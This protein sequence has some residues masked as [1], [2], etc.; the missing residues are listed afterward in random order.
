MQQHFFPLHPSTLHVPPQNDAPQLC[1]P[2]IFQCTPDLLMQLVVLSI[3]SCTPTSSAFTQKLNYKCS[4]YICLE[5]SFMQIVSSHYTPS[6][7]HILKMM[8]AATILQPIAEY[9]TLLFL[10]FSTPLL[11]LLFSTILLLPHAFICAHSSMFFFPLL[12]NV[13]FQLH[14]LHSY[15]CEFQNFKNAHNFQQQS[16]TAFDGYPVF[17]CP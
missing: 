17:S 7:L 12:F 11:L 14:S 9:S 13:V 8:N 2:S 1:L 10:L 16:Q 5:L 4:S 6:F 3:L 15:Y